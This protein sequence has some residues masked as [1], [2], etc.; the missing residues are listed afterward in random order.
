[1]ALK[2]LSNIYFEDKEISEIFLKESQI[3]FPQKEMMKLFV[4]N[5]EEE[6]LP[7]RVHV[8]FLEE[9]ISRKRT[10][11]MSL[12]ANSLA[13]QNIFQNRQED[14]RRVVGT[15]KSAFSEDLGKIKN[16]AIFLENQTVFKEKFRQRSF[17]FL[18]DVASRSKADL[19]YLK[20]FC[21]GS[22]HT[23]RM[24]QLGGDL[25]ASCMLKSTI[26]QLKLLQE[27]LKS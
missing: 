23:L 19:Y 3:Y 24:K 10:L 9:K 15:R 5:S 21:R 2:C 6:L 8:K 16:K 27:T 7:P 18:C 14:D 13:R 4:E 1:M 11:R 25:T 26:S 17:S 22:S 12:Q 20:T